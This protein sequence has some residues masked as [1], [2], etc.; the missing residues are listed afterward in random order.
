MPTVRPV[1]F[2]GLG[3]ACGPLASN[4]LWAHASCSLYVPTNSLHTRMRAHFPDSS[5]DQPTCG[6]G[7][8]K[9]PHR[10]KLCHPTSRCW[11]GFIPDPEWHSPPRRQ[12]CETGAPKRC[13]F[14]ADRKPAGSCHI[15]PWNFLT[16]SPSPPC[17]GPLPPSH[18]LSLSASLSTHTPSSSCPSEPWRTE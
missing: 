16:T 17:P 7:W 4:H 15:R 8:F 11:Q 18:P 3:H 1:L 9:E 10:G 14:P 2:F 13:C 5:C 6:N 12:P